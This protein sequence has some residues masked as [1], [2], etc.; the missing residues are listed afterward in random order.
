MVEVG[1]TKQ[2]LKTP[3]GQGQ[4]THAEAGSEIH[5]DEVLP[6]YEQFVQQYFE[7][8]RTTPK[9]GPSSAQPAVK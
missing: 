1:S 6:I 4:S 8:I 2:Q 7:K 5:R 9:N 3:V